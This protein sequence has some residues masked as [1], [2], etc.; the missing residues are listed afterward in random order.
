MELCS[1]FFHLCIFADNFAGI[2][3]VQIDLC[4]D[5]ATENLL[6][7]IA[8]LPRSAPRPNNPILEVGIV[9]KVKSAFATLPEKFAPLSSVAPRCL[10]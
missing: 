10:N 6:L 4:S 1:E 8:K 7:D 5:G 3:A 2:S 9:S